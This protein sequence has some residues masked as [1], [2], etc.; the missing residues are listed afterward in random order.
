MLLKTSLALAAVVLGVSAVHELPDLQIGDTMP[1][2][3][4]KMQDV[5]GKDIDLNGVK[6]TNGTLVIFSCNTCPFVI[7]GDGSAGWE[8]RYPEIGNACREAQVGMVL[9]NSNEAK[10]GAGD[11]FEDMRSHYKE[12]SYNSH[13]AL[14]KDHVL[15]DAFGARTTPHVFLFDKDNKLVYKGAIDD[16]VDDPKAVTKH[17]LKDALKAVAAG[18]A[19]DPP[20]TRNL[21]CSIKRVAHQH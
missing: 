10:R 14:D 19:I 7:G 17:W 18:K 3:D 9:V 11:G 6:R 5:G 12:H 13:Y 4:L 15:A 20:T 21:G 8:G 2:P 1:K 16:N